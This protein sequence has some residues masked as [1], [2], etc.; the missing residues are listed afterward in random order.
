MLCEEAKQ[1]HTGCW[2]SLSKPFMHFLAS[3]SSSQSDTTASSETLKSGKRTESEPGESRESSERELESRSVARECLLRSTEQCSLLHEVP[4]APGDGEKVATRNAVWRMSGGR[5]ERLR[6]LDF[7]IL[8]RHA[9]FSA[10]YC[11]LLRR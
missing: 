11:E 2:Q 9:V 8:R 7:L 10:P 1:K 6:R 5:Q 3:L 4:V